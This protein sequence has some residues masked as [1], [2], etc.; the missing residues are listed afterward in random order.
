MNTSKYLET[1]KSFLARYRV[2]VVSLIVLGLLG[3]TLFRLQAISNPQIDEEY[4]DQK[5]A[6]NPIT[7]EI[8]VDDELIEKIND[9]EAIPVDVTPD[10]LGTNDPFNP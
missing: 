7:G 10:N 4:L 5:R 8:K 2:I 9:L 1:T 6:D 3:Y